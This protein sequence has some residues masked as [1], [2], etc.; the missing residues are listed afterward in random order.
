MKPLL[1]LLFLLTTAVSFG[2]TRQIIQIRKDSINPFPFSPGVV[3]NGLLFASGQVGTNPQTG[4][5]VAGGIEAETKQTIYN[6]EAI[7][8]AG[9]ASLDDVV[10]VTVYL[11]NMDDFAKM[12]AVYR[13]F[14]KAGNFPARTTVGVAKLVYGAA[15]EMTM[16]AALPKK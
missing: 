9:G 6:V 1:V 11:S 13:T 2:Q 10:S 15:V 12:N 16:T 4:K 7:L 5:L 3:S 8:K 14:F